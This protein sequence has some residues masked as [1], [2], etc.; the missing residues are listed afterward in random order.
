MA[1]AITPDA[2]SKQSTVGGLLAGAKSSLSGLLS[3][4]SN[5]TAS[6]LASG[7]SSA[8]PSLLTNPILWVAV[9]VAGVVVYFAKFRSPS[10]KGIKFRR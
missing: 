8:T 7:G 2:T 9:V 5:S 4:G 1:D 3:G 6:G 10:R